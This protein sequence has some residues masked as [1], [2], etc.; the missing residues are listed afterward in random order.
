MMKRDWFH[1]GLGVGALVLSVFLTWGYTG[2]GYGF[3][4]N[5]IHIGIICFGC[6]IILLFINSMRTLSNG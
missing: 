6:G 5:L 4:W 2:L 1:F 3:N